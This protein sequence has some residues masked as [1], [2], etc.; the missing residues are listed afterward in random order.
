MTGPETVLPAV[1]LGTA[2]LAVVPEDRALATID[3]A[4]EAGIRYF[5]TAPLYGGGLAEERLGRVLKRSSKDVDVVVSTKC[6][7]T[8]DCGAAASGSGRQPDVWDFSET[9]TRRSLERS[10]ER[11]GRDRID[12]VFLHDIEAA[13]GQALNEALPVLR[14]LQAQGVIGLIGA[15]CNTVAGLLQALDAGASEVVLV[16]GRWTLLDRTAGEALFSRTRALGTRVVCGGILNSGLLA[17]PDAPGARFDY[18]PVCDTER[19]AARRLST[20]ADAAGVT[21]L[22]A[23]LQFPGRSPSVSTTLLGA[24]NPKELETALTAMSEAI[25]EPFWAAAEHEGIVA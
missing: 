7:R 24:S 4:L 25:P 21:L 10:R 19:S 5:D 15:G 2:A 17:D 3:R 6:G 18:R 8:R 22:A 23:A 9:A 12:A 16:A 1:G 11:L 13:P 14:E 20:L